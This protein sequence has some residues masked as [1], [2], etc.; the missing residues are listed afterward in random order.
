M[1]WIKGTLWIILSLFLIVS[2]LLT[3]TLLTANTL[4]YPGI[5]VKA[6]EGGGGASGVLSNATESIEGRGFVNTSSEEFDT[7]VEKLIA[8]FLSYLR[9]ETNE[10]NFT[11]DIESD[12]LRAFLE[13][14]VYRLPVCGSEE[15]LYSTEGDALCRP[16]N[17]T[18]SEFLDEVLAENN[19]T[20]PASQSVDLTSV[21]GI[22]TSGL[23]QIREGVRMYK[24]AIYIFLFLS[25]IFAMLIFVAARDIKKGSMIF[26]LDLVVAGIIVFISSLTTSLLINAPDFGIEIL[27]VLV[28]SI[29]GFIITRQNLYGVALVVSGGIVIGAS[30]F[31]KKSEGK[32]ETKALK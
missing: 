10:L 1:G 13:G 15:E 8:N 18:S 31:L 20:L 26:G 21:Y 3:V 24:I 2:L 29:K 23:G 25:L 19:I 9:G 17:K 22:N 6:L 14:Q 7:E 4:L 30:F 32:N 16:S 28:N 27:T 5:Y 11:I 12:T